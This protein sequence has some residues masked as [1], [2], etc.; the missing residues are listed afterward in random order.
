VTKKPW[1]IDE[2]DA[3]SPRRYMQAV[4]AWMRQVQA[5]IGSVLLAQLADAKKDEDE[6]PVDPVEA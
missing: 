5:V 1:K 3:P 6:G 2:R 4:R